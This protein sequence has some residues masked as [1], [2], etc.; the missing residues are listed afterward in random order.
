MPITFDE[1]CPETTP[2]RALK[3][4]RVNPVRKTANCP[5]DPH[6]DPPAEKLR[7][8]RRNEKYENPNFSGTKSTG[9]GT[10]PQDLILE[11]G[12]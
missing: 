11:S 12:W 8:N 7:R 3:F 4:K 1:D 2:E 10:K 6:T 5:S 9:N